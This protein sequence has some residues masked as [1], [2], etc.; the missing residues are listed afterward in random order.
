MHLGLFSEL[1]SKEMT[2]KQF[3]LHVG[4]LLL[5][6]TGISTLLKTISDPHLTSASKVRSG[7]GGGPY[8]R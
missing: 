5:A 3:L 1:L 6:I 7:F 8:G 4:I 2:R